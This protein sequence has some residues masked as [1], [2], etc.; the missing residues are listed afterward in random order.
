VR[1][2]IALA[3]VV[4]ALAALFAWRR[5]RVDTAFRRAVDRRPK[6]PNGIVVGAEGF[7]LDR[8]GAPAV[9]LLHG[10]GDTPQTLRYLAAELHDRGFHVAAPL[11]PGHGRDLDA[12]AR[13]TAREI[14]AAARAT[15]AGLRAKREWVGLIGLSMGGAV[16]VQL[17]ADAPDLPALGLAAPYLAMPPRIARAASLA[18]LWGPLAPVVQSADGVSVLDAEE[19]ARSL[20]Y[21]AFTPSALRA[22]AEI[23]RSA[24]AALPRVAAPTLFLQSRTDNRISVSAAEHAFAR[25]GSAEKRLEWISGAAHIIT[26]DYGRDQVNALLASWMEAHRISR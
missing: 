6:G 26:V 7:V 10:A 1:Q 9:L 23:V 14:V 11:L 25:L 5:R 3:T 15:F 24:A 13:V 21:G 12:F 2:L 18:W 20:A 22:L 4:F 17:A 8:P 19:R 16:A